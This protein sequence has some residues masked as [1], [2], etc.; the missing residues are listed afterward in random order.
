MTGSNLEK[1]E[2]RKSLGMFT[3]PASYSSSATPPSRPDFARHRR[4]SSD[5][6]NTFLKYMSSVTSYP[7]QRSNSPPRPK[8][9]GHLHTDSIQSEIPI[10]TRTGTNTHQ[11]QQQQQH[12]HH[13]HHAT[14]EFPRM[15]RKSLLRTRTSVFGSLRS[16]RSV[17]DSESTTG[18]YSKGSVEDDDS[19]LHQSRNPS[20]SMVIHHG[21]V[22]TTG[23]MWRRRS[24]Y[25]V[26]TDT[27]LIR[28]K[29]QNKAADVF[30]SMAAPN[31]RPRPPS[32]QSS[33]SISSVQDS[34]TVSYGDAAASIPL[35]NIIAVYAL[36]DGRLSSTVEL[37]YLDERTHKVAVIQ[38]HTPDLQELNLWMAGIRSAARL[39]RFTN[40]L[41]IDQTSIESVVS[42]LEHERDYDPLTFRLFRVVQVASTKSTAGSSDDLTKVSPTGCYLAIGS[43]KLHLIP[44]QK[45]SSIR[46]P[47]T[48]NDLETSSSSFGLMALTGLS[49]E[50]GDDSLHLTF[51]YVKYVYNIMHS[52]ILIDLY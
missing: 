23:G 44:F 47:H 30:P 43:H 49:M 41:P 13:H 9:R 14:P 37:A 31:S 39:S 24:Q 12:H 10:I 40:P 17:E 15:R 3:Y 45:A 32:R 19:Y 21:D 27:H 34:H 33:V 35:H 46:N 22:Q 48:S 7:A 4:C 11:Q 50:W 16:Q 36:D 29:S 28:F 38:M 51:R 8:S 20:E 42:V 5:D 6:S 25:L 1:K 52:N 26:L 18:R 2:W